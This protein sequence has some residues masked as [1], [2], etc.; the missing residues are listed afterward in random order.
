[1][2]PVRFWD[3]RRTVRLTRMSTKTP[4]ASGLA[5][6]GLGLRSDHYGDLLAEPATK[7]DWLEILTENYLVP[8]GPPLANLEKIRARY[9]LAMH[10][11]SL[12]IGSSDPLDM[13]YLR[14]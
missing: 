9:P 5:G 7:V 2:R 1:R 6:F 11:V 10:G 8:G 14:Q 3:K 12:S 13:D 4:S